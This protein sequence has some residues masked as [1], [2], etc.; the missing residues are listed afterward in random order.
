LYIAAVFLFF[1]AKFLELGEKE[2]E[3]AKGTKE[4]FC[5][6][7]GENVPKSITL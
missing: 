2:K 5:G 6:R 1:R 4:F 7:G 3:G